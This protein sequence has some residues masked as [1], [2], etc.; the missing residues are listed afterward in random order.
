MLTESRR[1]RK[2]LNSNINQHARTYLDRECPDEENDELASPVQYSFSMNPFPALVLLLLG[3][4]MGSHTQGTA[5]S[6]MIHKQ[7]GQLLAGASFA[8]FLTYLIMY[9]SPPT[10]ILPSRPPTELLA[11]FGMTAGGI[12]FMASVSTF[13]CSFSL[14]RHG[15]STNKYTS[16]PVTLSMV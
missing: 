11:S 9:L 8:R 1:I 7:W 4:M 5:M 15:S 12:I 16:S 10:S 14:F 2:L 13:P 6:S 3:I